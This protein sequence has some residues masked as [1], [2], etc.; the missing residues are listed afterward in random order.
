[1][2][3]VQIHNGPVADRPNLE[4]RA[5]N[6]LWIEDYLRTG[7]VLEGLERIVR[8]G[9]TRFV[10]FICRG[11]DGPQVKQLIDTGVFHLLNLVYT[12]MNPSAVIEP[13]RGLEVDVDFGQVIPYAFKKGV[14]TAVYSPLAG[15]LLSDNIIRGGQPHPLS[16]AGR[17]GNPA[18]AERR[19]RQTERA[20][21]FSFLSDL[22]HHSLAQAAVRY[23]LMEPGVTSVLGGFSDIEQLEEIAAVSGAGAL[24]E[25][26]LVRIDMAW[27]GN[28]GSRRSV[29]P[30]P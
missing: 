1:V 27:R 24:S 6:I 8:A 11:N 10:G 26:Q 17:G 14:G 21:A 22:E 9:K 23:I 3:I 28:L 25:E 2:D 16:G 15:G 30:A 18:F 13:P 29:A 4:G 20:A 19:R 7:G 5:Y 12:L